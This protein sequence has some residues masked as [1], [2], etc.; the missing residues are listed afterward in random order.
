MIAKRSG[1]SSVR[2]RGQAKQPTL[3]QLKRAITEAY[4]R[5]FG[6]G[7]GWYPKKEAK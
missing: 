1:Y 3:E 7:G 2:R 5:R 6:K 4:Q